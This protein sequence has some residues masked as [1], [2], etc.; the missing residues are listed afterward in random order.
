MSFSIVAILNTKPR[1]VLFVNVDSDN[2]KLVRYSL[3][4]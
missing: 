1:T 4:M 3:K 2:E